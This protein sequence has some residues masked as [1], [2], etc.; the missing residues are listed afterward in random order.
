MT[1]NIK[2]IQGVVVSNKPSK[3]VIVKVKYLKEH[4]LYKKR[5]YNSRKFVAHDE[6][7]RCQVGDLVKIVPC[8]P[9]SA[10]KRFYVKEIKKAV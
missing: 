9:L 5:V 6:H 3:T 4:P 2:S 7:N 10:R 1:K 8:R